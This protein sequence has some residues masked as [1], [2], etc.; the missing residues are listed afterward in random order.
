[1]PSDDFPA[2]EPPRPSPSGAPLPTK[3]FQSE[4]LFR[5]QRMVCIDHEGAIYRLQITSRGKLILQK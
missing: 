5:G 2:D 4:E 1:M 3:L